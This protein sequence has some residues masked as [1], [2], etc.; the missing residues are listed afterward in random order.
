MSELKTCLICRKADELS[1]QDLPKWSKK[2][3]NYS[4]YPQ[5]VTCDERFNLSKRDT[6]DKIDTEIKETG[7]ELSLDFGKQ[8]KDHWIYYWATNPSEDRLKIENVEKAYGEYEN[9]GLQK[10]NK[11]GKVTLK[12]NAPQPYIEDE[13]T[14]CRHVHYLLEDK[15]EEI[16]SDMKS[17]RVICHI[18]I[19]ELDKM[20]QN[21]DAMI[22]NALPEKYYKKEKI[23]TS[24]NLPLESLKGLTKESKQKRV[25]DF[26]K[27]N[28]SKYPKIEDKISKKT[29]SLLDIPVVTYCAHSKCN[30]SDKLIDEL[31]GCNV[32][33]VFEWFEGM[34]GWNKERTFF[35]V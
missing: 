21:K 4:P 18:S 13:K 3:G 15:S 1:K 16:W 2:E 26:I 24:L 29:L 27:K 22:I 7:I 33:N 8:Q 35:G 19:E 34:E 32:N 12:M 31:Y 5:M 11:E 28:L 30:A 14:Y 17:I 20:I 10:T 23:P 25:E 6:L 9:H